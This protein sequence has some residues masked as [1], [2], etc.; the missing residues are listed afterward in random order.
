MLLRFLIV[1]SLLGPVFGCYGMKRDRSDGDIISFNQLRKKEEINGCYYFLE[2]LNEES[3]SS[4]ILRNKASKDDK[5]FK[6]LIVAI[7]AGRCK[8]CIDIVMGNA[9]LLEFQDEDGNTPL[10]IAIMSNQLD[11]IKY[12]ITCINKYNINKILNECNLNSE[13]AYDC[14]INHSSTNPRLHP[15][16]RQLMEKIIHYD[17]DNDDDFL[18]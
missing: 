15:L 18:K 3:N 9:S 8:E 16:V 6:E 12:I 17:N 2:F 7:K 13:S 5:L 4:I 1:V 10:H 11:I 14:A